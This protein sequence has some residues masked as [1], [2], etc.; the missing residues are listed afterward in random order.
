M[1]LH[2]GSQYPIEDLSRQVAAKLG[3]LGLL[4]RNFSRRS[5]SNP[6]KANLLAAGPVQSPERLKEHPEPPNLAKMC[7]RTEFKTML[8][9]EA[10]PRTAIL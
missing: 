6:A 10:A 1:E 9:H 5:R 2:P 8:P 4:G 7:L 3:S